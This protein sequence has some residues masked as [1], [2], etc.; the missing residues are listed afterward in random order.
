MAADRV[1]PISKTFHMGEYKRLLCPAIFLSLRCVIR[2]FLEEQEAETKQ[3]YKEDCIK[4][5]RVIKNCNFSSNKYVFEISINIIFHEVF[6]QLD[7][8]IKLLRSI[9]DDWIFF[10]NSLRSE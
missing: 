6:S 2:C 1:Y 10:V 5:A 8:F 4:G 3:S 9:Q 7:N